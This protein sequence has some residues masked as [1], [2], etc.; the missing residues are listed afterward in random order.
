[1]HLSTNL[2][3]SSS[4][5][6]VLCVFVSRSRLEHFCF[7]PHSSGSKLIPYNGFVVTADGDFVRSGSMVYTG[8]CFLD[9]HV[10]N[11]HV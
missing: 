7:Y 5:R 9:P 2:G 1:M 8:R 4:C 3:F 11:R 6:L 10:G